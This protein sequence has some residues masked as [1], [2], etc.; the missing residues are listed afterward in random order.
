MSEVGAHKYWHLRTVTGHNIWWWE[1]GNMVRVRTLLSGGEHNTDHCHHRRDR[2]PGPAP[3]LLH[4]QPPTLGMVSSCQYKHQHSNRILRE[5]IIDW[6]AVHSR[7]KETFRKTARNIS[8]LHIISKHWTRL[9][10]IG[11]SVLSKTIIYIYCSNYKQKRVSIS[12][13]WR[14]VV[15]VHNNVM[16]CQQRAVL[17]I[18]IPSWWPRLCG[19]GGGWV[20]A[21]R[22]G[23]WSLEG[24]GPRLGR[25]QLLVTDPRRGLHWHW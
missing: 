23:V 17:I 2:I 9:G 15:L 10:Y 1:Y 21:C 19:Q 5:D 4:H 20:E 11:R 16:S 7:E 22:G 3:S 18:Q 14:K 12:S 24:G 13:S 25:G 6:Y 8:F